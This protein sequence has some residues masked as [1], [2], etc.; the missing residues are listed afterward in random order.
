MFTEY[1]E[2]NNFLLKHSQVS[3]AQ[4]YKSQLSK[5]LLIST[6]SYFET[7]V[8]E[9]MKEI[10]RSKDCSLLHSFLEKKALSRQYHTL[11]NWNQGAAG[12]KQFFSY[13]GADFS[14]YVKEKEKEDDQL[15]NSFS[16]FMQI[17]AK[18][19]KLVHDN[20]ATFNLDWT[21]EEIMTKFETAT[22]FTESLLQLVDD[23][24]KTKK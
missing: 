24:R 11:F 20:Y 15:T 6:A 22:Y 19:N 2:N 17:G 21:P 18:R 12:I 10:F 7:K 14:K 23:F 5:I 9:L 4:D 16:A 13:L 3:F 8:T 1:E